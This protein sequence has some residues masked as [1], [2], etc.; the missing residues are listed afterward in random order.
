MVLLLLLT[1]AAPVPYNR[2][3]ALITDDVVRAAGVLVARNLVL[4][5]AH[6]VHGPEQ[7]VGCGDQVIQGH[8]AKI[9]VA[10]DL[11][12][13]S[14]SESCD[15]VNVTKLATVEA[16]E[17]DWLSAQGYPS[18]T[19]RT[20]VG[21][22]ASYETLDAQ[23]FIRRYMV[24]DLVIAGGNSG[25]PVLNSKGMLAGIVYGKACYQPAN[26]SCYGLA[27]PLKELRTF[28]EGISL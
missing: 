11:A 26:T 6:A 15:K 7:L 8:I 22:V 9:D 13:F 25:G 16:Q 12:L 10:A 23:D 1:I 24:M 27:V 14:L 19:R 4:T 5:S 17:G 3:V 2:S 21:V 28:L 20:T 18:Q